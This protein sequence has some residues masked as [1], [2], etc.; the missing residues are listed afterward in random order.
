MLKESG[1]IAI[2]GTCQTWG[3][4]RLS[5]EIMFSFEIIL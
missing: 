4:V 5:C 2:I 1:F 3:H